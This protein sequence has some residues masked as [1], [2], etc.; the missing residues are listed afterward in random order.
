M[1]FNADTVPSFLYLVHSDFVY[2]MLSACYCLSCFVLNVY[3]A[4]I[5]LYI[6]LICA[7][8][9][10]S[11]DHLY[12]LNDQVIPSTDLFFPP[13]GTSVFQDELNCFMLLSCDFSE[14]IHEE[15]DK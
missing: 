1:N 3:C 14:K 5:Q 11:A 10:R 12:V 13:D 6:C 8:I 15:A 7:Q 9:M 2:W 4:I